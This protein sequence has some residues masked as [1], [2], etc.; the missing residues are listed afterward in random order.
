MFT[1]ARKEHNINLFFHTQNIILLLLLLLKV[2]PSPFHH[3]MPTE[4]CI[5]PPAECLVEKLNDCGVRVIKSQVYRKMERN[6]L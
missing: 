5:V 3:N 2:P 4:H 1:T 6:I